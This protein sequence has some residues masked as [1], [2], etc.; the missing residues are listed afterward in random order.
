ML[1]VEENGIEKA[2]CVADERRIK[3]GETDE[4]AEATDAINGAMLY[5]KGIALIRK[6]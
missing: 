6:V 2:I 5:K 3:A 1:P 4:V